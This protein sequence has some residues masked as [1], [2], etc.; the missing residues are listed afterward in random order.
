[1]TS[2]RNPA[3]TDVQRKAAA[4][5]YPPV[6]AVCV[7]TGGTGFVGSRVVEM[8]V[9]RGATKVI[10][11]DIVPVERTPLAWRHPKIQ[12]V[13]GDI[14][15]YEQVAAAIQ[16]AD[17]VWHIAA[18]V[19]PFHPIKL[20]NAVNYVG[21]LNVIKA[22]QAHNVGKL[23]F[24]SSP[25]TRFQGSLWQRPCLDGP[26]SDD[27]PE[28][29]LK[30]Y[31]QIYAETKAMGEMAARQ[32]CCD[33][34]L[35]IAVAPHQVY[36]PRDNLFLPNVLEAGGTGKLRIFGEGLNRVCF[37]HVDNYAHALV[38][39]ER[40]LFKGSPALAKFYIATDGNTHPEP[41]AYCVFWKEVDKAVVGMGFR[42]MYTK[43]HLPFWFIYSIALASNFVSWITGITFKLNV[44]SVFA[45]TM[46]RWFDIANTERDLA[47]Q[48]IIGFT[49]G[50]ADTIQWFKANWLPGF[51]K[52]DNKS[53][54]GLAR[55][56][57]EKISIQDAGTKKAN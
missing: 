3:L 31:M 5:Q 36:G 39:A 28:L 8:L 47:Y 57:A 25:S 27:M 13:V 20:Y 50:W 37:S 19:G 52:A 2:E 14:A 43:F 35:T 1:M 12:Y 33:A 51:L 40:Q 46:H 45:L 7:V 32:A 44:F 54:I 6:P 29:P 21:T 17:C 56:S 41:K 48:P 15:N 16:G 38:I 9:E 42:S 4:K 18:A 23:V 34:L 30:S 55:G 11:F 49:E 10:S 53:I 22:C 24:S 26:S